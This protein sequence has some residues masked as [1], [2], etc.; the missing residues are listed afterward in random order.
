MRNVVRSKF[1]EGRIVILIDSRSS[2]PLDRP[3]NGVERG[4]GTSSGN[5]D[6]QHFLEKGGKIN[7]HSRRNCYVSAERESCKS[8]SLFMPRFDSLVQTRLP[9][10][11]SVALTLID[12]RGRLDSAMTAR[13]IDLSFVSREVV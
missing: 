5:G 3:R 4:S 8:S 12:V 13:W 6:H 9:L 11:M 7:C 1:P 10:L 2:D